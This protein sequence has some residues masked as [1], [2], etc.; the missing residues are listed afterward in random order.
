[1]VEECGRQLTTSRAHTIVY[2]EKVEKWVP[3]SNGKTGG[4]TNHFP[5]EDQTKDQI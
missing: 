2:E 5:K 3:S 1:M 4:K